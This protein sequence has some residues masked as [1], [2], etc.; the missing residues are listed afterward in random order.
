MSRKSFAAGVVV[1]AGHLSKS[2]VEMA[3][4][5]G[6]RCRKGVVLFS[7]VGFVLSGGMFL[8]HP[9][10]I[11][12]SFSSSE[13]L[14]ALLLVAGAYP[15]LAILAFWQAEKS[16]ARCIVILLGTLGVAIIGLMIWYLTAVTWSGDFAVFWLLAYAGY[17]WM[18]VVILVFLLIIM[19]FS[20]WY[21]HWRN[22][23]WNQNP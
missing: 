12:D 16:R 20:S 21:I 5:L 15:L 13:W 17:Q 2:Q 14:L 22:T 18:L 1:V 23:R 8:G 6:R 11:A 10:R 3:V 19:S 9:G 7:A 4:K